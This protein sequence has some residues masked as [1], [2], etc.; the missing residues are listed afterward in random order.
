MNAVFGFMVQR[1]SVA[2]DPKAGL[3]P[4]CKPVRDRDGGVGGRAAADLSLSASLL[5]AECVGRGVQT[6]VE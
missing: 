6:L 2:G 4:H 1:P 3:V 5:V